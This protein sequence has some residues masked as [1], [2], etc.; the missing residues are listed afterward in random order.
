MID[1]WI[2]TLREGRNSYLLIHPE[3]SDRWLV[4][5]MRDLSEGVKRHSLASNPDWVAFFDGP[6]SQMPG[7]PC[8]MHHFLYAS[9]PS[10]TVV[11]EVVFFH[12]ND[13]AIIKFAAS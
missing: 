11:N 10:A 5:P 1:E 9:F 13:F 8:R 2:I 4:G 12:Q 3:V 7:K 6:F